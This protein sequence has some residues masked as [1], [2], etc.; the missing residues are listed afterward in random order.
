MIT[1]NNKAAFYRPVL[2][3][4]PSFPLYVWGRRCLHL[5]AVAGRCPPLPWALPSWALDRVVD[6][7]LQ[8]PP[9]RPRQARP[10]RCRRR[11]PASTSVTAPSC[12]SSSQRLSSPSRTARQRASPPPS[13]SNPA[14]PAQASKP[15]IWGSRHGPGVFVSNRFA[16]LQLVPDVPILVQ[17]LR[18]SVPWPCK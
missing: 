11:S 8:A 9:L 4:H 12:T 16:R 3:N 18:V 15:R 7:V 5:V 10:P 1:R 17:V 14:T 2:H 6:R 13:G